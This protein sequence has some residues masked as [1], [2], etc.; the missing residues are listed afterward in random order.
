MTRQTHLLRLAL[1]VGRVP[2]L[3]LV[4]GGGNLPG[5]LPELLGRGL[6]RHIDSLGC[7]ICGC[8]E[9]EEDTFVMF[10]R[11]EMLDFFVSAASEF[12]GSKM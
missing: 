11:T 4:R 12:V 7:L 8:G 9:D 1:V 2:L 6:G 5:R 10:A 3:R